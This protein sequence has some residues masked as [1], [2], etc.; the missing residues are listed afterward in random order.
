MS[1]K[2]SFYNT[3]VWKQQRRYVWLKQNCL[4]AV[5]N[6]PVYVDGISDKAIPKE[7]RVKGIVHHKQWLT[8]NNVNDDE[9]ALDE[10]NLI[11]VCITCHNQIHEPKRATRSDLTF[12]EN[13]QLIPRPKGDKIQ[14]IR[15]FNQV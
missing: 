9:I 14:Q 1:G 6:K 4:C 15:E 10:N 11:G 2:N 7:Q 5:C 3:K 13:G 12:D 8:D